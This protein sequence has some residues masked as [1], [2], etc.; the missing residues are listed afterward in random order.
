MSSRDTSFLAK[1]KGEIQEYLELTIDAEEHREALLRD[2]W[3]IV[4]PAVARSYWNGVEAGSSGRAKPKAK[5]RL[6]NRTS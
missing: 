1:L 4:R 5:A 6:K 3:D 2:V